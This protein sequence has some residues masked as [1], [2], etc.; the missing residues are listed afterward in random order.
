MGSPGNGDSSSPARAQEGLDKALRHRLGLLGCLGQGWG[1]D[2]TILGGP[3]QLRM[4]HDT[5]SR[6]DIPAEPL[7]LWRLGLGMSQHSHK[8]LFVTCC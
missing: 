2:S 5:D 1:L 3:F 6:E 4:F 8:E 7:L